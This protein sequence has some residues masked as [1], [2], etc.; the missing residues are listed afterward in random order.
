MTVSNDPGSES[1]VDLPGVPRGSKTLEMLG[2]NTDDLLLARGDSILL[3]TLRST[4]D[5]LSALRSAHI[6][7]TF[8]QLPS[9]D[10]TNFL[11]WIASSVDPE[12]RRSRTRSFI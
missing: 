3:E 4:H 12:I 7:D 6:L 9:V 8:L 11:R 2:I 1:Y 10:R 5:L